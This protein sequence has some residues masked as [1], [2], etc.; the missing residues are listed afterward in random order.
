MYKGWNMN[1]KNQDDQSKKDHAANIFA[2]RDKVVATDNNDGLANSVLSGSYGK[3]PS[4][5]SLKTQT[6]GTVKTA[7]ELLAELRAVQSQNQDKHPKD[8]SGISQANLDTTTDIISKF[9]NT[10]FT[11]GVPTGM[12]DKTAAELTNKEKDDLDKYI[13]QIAGARNNRDL[14]TEVKAD[15]SVSNKNNMSEVEADNAT[16]RFR[17]IG[18]FTETVAAPK[19]QQSAGEKLEQ[20]ISELE[21]ITRIV[22]TKLNTRLGKNDSNN[23]EGGNS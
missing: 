15:K 20:D 10:E 21:D 22:E 13:A 19:K 12:G 1:N 7:S 16:A 23:T 8:L 14:L 6:A 11:K 3:L 2:Q 9:T 17:N 4:K 5:D 18:F